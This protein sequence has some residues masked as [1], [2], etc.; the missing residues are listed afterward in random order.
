MKTDKVKDKVKISLNKI[1]SVFIGVKF[2]RSECIVNNVKFV[3]N[4]CQF[5]ILG[6]SMV[7]FCA[8]VTTVVMDD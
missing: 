8:I 2:K 6:L 5:Y 1:V 3:R 7:G 4:N